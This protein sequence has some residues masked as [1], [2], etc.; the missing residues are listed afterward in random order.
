M[1]TPELKKKTVAYIDTEH[2]LKTNIT[3]FENRKKKNIK[4][5]V[6]SFA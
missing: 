5:P 4:I 1:R 6:R 2:S 3:K